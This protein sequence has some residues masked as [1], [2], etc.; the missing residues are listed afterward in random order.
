MATDP[1]KVFEIIER[2]GTGGGS[3]IAMLQQIQA[4][5]HYLPRDAL[6]LIAERTGLPLSD[7]FSTATFYNAFS[8]TPRGRHLVSVCLGTACHVKGAE[9]LTDKIARELDIEPGGTSDDLEFSLEKVR[10]I[11]CCALAPVVRIDDDTYGHLTQRKIP[12]VLK[13]YEREKDD[14]DTQS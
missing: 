10:C 3:L 4:E 1:S 8:L 9:K 2:C 6:V 13:K 11:G 7:V 5:Y 12:S 14:E